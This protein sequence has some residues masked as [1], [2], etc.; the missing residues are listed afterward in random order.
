M[1]PDDMRQKVAH[2]VRG[3]VLEGE[4]DTI[5]TIR[6]I[7]CSSYPTSRT[8]KKDFES[9]LRIKEEQA[10]F[11]NGYSKTNNLF[12]DT[13]PL[14]TSHDKITKIPTLV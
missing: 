10:E 4:A 1:L 2:I 13:L 6:N 12:I 8:V 11:L 14:F 7:L 3:T 5:T 9:K